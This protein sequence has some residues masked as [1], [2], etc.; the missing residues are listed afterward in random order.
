MKKSSETLYRCRYGKV[1]RKPSHPCPYEA[2]IND[3]SD[4]QYC[5]CCD[6]CTQDCGD[7]L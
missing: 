4:P 5:N 1:H 6:E 2:E 3:N 7:A